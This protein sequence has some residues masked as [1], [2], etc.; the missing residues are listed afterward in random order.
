MPWIIAQLFLNL[1]LCQGP[2]LFKQVLV[3]GHFRVLFLNHLDKADIYIPSNLIDKEPKLLK[4]SF[5]TSIRQIS[6]PTGEML[7]KMDSG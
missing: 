5:K 1:T 7:F 6:L 4:N 2:L 3:V